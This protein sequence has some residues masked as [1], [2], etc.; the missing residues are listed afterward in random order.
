MD[1]CVARPQPATQQRLR[2]CGTEFGGDDRHRI[3]SANA[4]SPDSRM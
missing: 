3:H 4:E 2:V 1:V